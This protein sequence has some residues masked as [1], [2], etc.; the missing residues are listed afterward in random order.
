MSESPRAAV[1]GKHLEPESRPLPDTRPGRGS[2]LSW[3]V[4]DAG[5]Q[6]SHPFL[7]PD[8]DCPVFLTSFQKKKMPSET[9]NPFANT[10]VKV[11]A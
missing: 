1:N 5:E 6:P 4:C 3:P 9:R 2:L 10:T 7:S 8:V 11:S